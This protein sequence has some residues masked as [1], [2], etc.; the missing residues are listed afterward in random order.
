MAAE[1]YFTKAT[2][3]F[4]KQLAANN[5]RDWFLANKERYERCA[6]DPFLRLIADLA[7]A[8]EKAKLP[9]VADPRPSGGSMM[10]IYRDIRFA[11][12]K[13]PYK[14]AIAAHFA[15][16]NAK[17][18]AAPGFY[19][20]IQPGKS[21]IGGGVWRPEPKALRKIRDA[22]ASDPKAWQK[23]TAPLRGREEGRVHKM[24]SACGLIGESLTRPPAGFPAD[25][26][27]IED[28]K[29]KDFAISSSLT[30][31]EVCG[32]GFN[33]LVLERFRASAPFLKFL[34]KAV[35]LS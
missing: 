7:P 17:D 22:I 26:P 28:I 2:L 23:A 11:K 29:R 12:D 4:L 21:M 32:P 33:K 6:R 34:S 13:S 16:Q 10:R 30:D 9:Y 20:H 8:F 1:T 31:S 24:G 35:G 15:H 18:D 19:L 14:I 3:D 27:F 25:H 5:E